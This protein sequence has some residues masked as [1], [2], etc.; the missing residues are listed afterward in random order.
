VH[1]LRCKYY[2]QLQAHA[3]IRLAYRHRGETALPA[4]TTLW[5]LFLLGFYGL[6]QIFG[7]FQRRRPVAPFLCL[8]PVYLLG[9][10]GYCPLISIALFPSG[11][12]IALKVVVGRD[13]TF[14]NGLQRHF[15][16]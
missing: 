2:R 3:T 14:R 6:A 16:V 10:L 9:I 5:T 15:A 8:S 1:L 7:E 12:I 13:K 11:H 4:L